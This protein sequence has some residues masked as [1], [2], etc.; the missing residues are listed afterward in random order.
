L[1]ELK[2]SIE[3]NVKKIKV[4]GD[5]N[6]ITRQVKNTIHCNSLHLRNYRKELH[7]I[8][9][10]LEA[11]NIVVIPR[12]KNTLFDSL[13]TASLSLSP[14][15]DYE[16]FWFIVELLYKPSVTNNISNW[17]L[18]EGYEHIIKILTNQEN[19]KYLAI[20]D[21]ILQEKLVYTDPCEQRGE[22][23]HSMRKPRFHMI[24]KGVSNLENLFDLREIFKGSINTKTGRSCPM[25][26]TVS[27]GTLEN[28]KNINLGKTTSKEERRAY[29]KLFREYQ[30]VFVW[31]YQ[32]LKTYDTRIIQQTIP[33]KPRVKPFQHKL[34]KY[35]QSLKPLMSEELKKLLDSKIIF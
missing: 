19:F 24:P 6:I 16:S 23:Y 10:H 32:Y 31:S 26:K 15:E 3:L 4:F 21:K 11:F 20:D 29:L 34:Q 7:R 35:H 12:T 5:S 27:L 2:K 18:F 25:Y 13:A 30:D 28:P 9:E 14:L 17:K 33:L 22:T 8:I 1:N